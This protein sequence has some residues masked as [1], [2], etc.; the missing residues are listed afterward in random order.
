MIF[1]ME[2]SNHENVLSTSNLSQKPFSISLLFQIKFLP[3]RVSFSLT[4]LVKN[5]EE[6]AEHV[7]KAENKAQAQAI[8]QREKQKIETNMNH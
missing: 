2:F 3:T 5:E 4:H 8:V 7:E 1:E 6:K